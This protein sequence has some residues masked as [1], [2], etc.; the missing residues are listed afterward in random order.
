MRIDDDWVLDAPGHYE[1]VVECGFECIQMTKSGDVSYSNLQ[2]RSNPFT[3]N[4]GIPN[5]AIQK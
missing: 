4:V 5:K 2:A 3:V 1:F